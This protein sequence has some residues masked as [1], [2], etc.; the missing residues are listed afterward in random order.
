[1]QRKISWLV[2]LC[3]ALGLQLQAFAQQLPPEE[4]D[5]EAVG[6]VSV[7]GD[8]PTREVAK[9]ETVDRLAVNGQNAQVAGTV[10]GDV[11]VVNGS[12]FVEKGAKIGGSVVVVGGEVKNAEA[13]KIKVVRLGREMLDAFPKP[14][15][16]TPPASAPGDVRVE[17]SGDGSVSVSVGS[18]PAPVVVAQNGPVPAR[19]VRH[20][21]EDWFGGQAAL[22]SR[23]VYSVVGVA[24]LW[25]IGLL[26][27]G[28][29]REPAHA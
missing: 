19:A 17:R 15:Q 12:L 1:M 14:G 27:R 23:I 9:G 10:E 21:K 11:L 5:A 2:A 6:G 24:G 8:T 18:G 3:L 16:P 7:H 20:E 13:A 29:R 28:A 25:C 4:G 22:V 26:F